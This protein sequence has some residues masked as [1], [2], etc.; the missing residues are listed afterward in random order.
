MGG[1]CTGGKCLKGGGLRGGIGGEHRLSF[2][3]Q[4]ASSSSIQVFSKLRIRAACLD[5]SDLWKEGVW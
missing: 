4:N 5:Q 3:A 2:E 1:K